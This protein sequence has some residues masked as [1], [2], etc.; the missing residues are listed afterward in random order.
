ML[1]NIIPAID[2][3][4]NMC[5]RLYQ[6]ESNKTTVYNHNPVEQAISFEQAG[7]KNL[8]II[9]IDAAVEKITANKQTIINIK[10]NVS[11]KN[12]LG[13]GIRSHDQIKFWFD[14]GIDN[15]IIGSMAFLEPKL[16]LKI[17]NEYPNKIIIAIDDKNNIPMISGWSK[18]ANMS[19][20]SACEYYEN[21]KIKG[22]IFTDIDRD[23]TLLGLNMDKITNF[24]NNT[25]HKVTVGGGLKNINDIKNLCLQNLSN[26]DGVIIGKAYYDGKINLNEAF[27]VVQNA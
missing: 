18:N 19:T 21:E 17:I 24:V 1:I 11:M 9:D 14:N 13:G 2:L 3:K 10:K 4:N 7:C 23:G 22:Y 12:Q 25:K 16:L 15:L 5:V 27:K 26:I 8:H 6:G 20:I